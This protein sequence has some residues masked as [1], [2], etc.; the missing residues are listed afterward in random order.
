MGRG[1]SEWQM[2]ILRLTLDCGGMLRVRDILEALWAWKPKPEKEGR[3][4]GQV[5]SRGS[6]GAEKYSRVHSTLSRTLK[7][8]RQRRLVEIFKG[9]NSTLIAL[10][11]AGKTEAKEI[12]WEGEEEVEEAP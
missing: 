10:T 9:K 2:T 11:T 6:I 5:F 4:G 8:L 12:Y 3:N 7:R 1:L